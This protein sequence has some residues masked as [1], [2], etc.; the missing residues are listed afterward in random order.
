MNKPRWG[1]WQG[2]G[3]RSRG[4]NSM[5]KGPAPWVCL[6]G[7]QQTVAGLGLQKQE[8]PGWSWA[9]SEGTGVG[10]AKLISWR[11]SGMKT[12]AEVWGIG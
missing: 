3:W 1:F 9:V 2:D 11:A 8:T 4:E 10:H 6:A 5:C 7:G 12:L